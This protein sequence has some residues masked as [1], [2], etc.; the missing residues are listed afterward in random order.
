VNTFKFNVL[1]VYTFYIEETENIDITTIG[2]EDRK[3]R[4]V[5]NSSKL[6]RK[7][8]EPKYDVLYI[9]NINIMKYK[10]HLMIN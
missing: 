1:K 10:D 8:L 4:K 9:A 5:K 2:Y 6:S 7:F 3:E